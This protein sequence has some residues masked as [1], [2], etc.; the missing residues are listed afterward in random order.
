MGE[1]ETVGDFQHIS[2][3]EFISKMTNTMID[4]QKHA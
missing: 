2:S 4:N 3:L 1:A